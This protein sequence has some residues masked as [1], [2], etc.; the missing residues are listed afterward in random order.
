MHLQL[1]ELL[2]AAREAVGALLAGTPAGGHPAAA[3][4]D[5]GKCPEHGRLG[6]RPQVLPALGE[7]DGHAAWEQVPQQ[8][9]GDQ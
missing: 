2:E 6:G 4:V 7:L 5:R 9:P 1:G 3:G 8:A